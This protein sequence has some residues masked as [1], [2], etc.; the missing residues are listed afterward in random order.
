MNEKLITDYIDQHT[1]SYVKKYQFNSYL[2]KNDHF[3]KFHYYM[4]DNQLQEISIFFELNDYD[5]IQTTFTEDINEYE[6]AAIITDALK[7]IKKINHNS[8]V[9]PKQI[10]EFIKLKNFYNVT[11]E[12]IVV[13]LNYIL[14]HH[15]INQKSIDIFYSCY[16]NHFNDLIEQKDF[17]QCLV[18][19]TA[20]FDTIMY[21]TFWTGTFNDYLDQQYYL[22]L[23]YIKTIFNI[24]IHKMNTSV[25]VYKDE[26][27][28][29]LSNI[30]H[31]PRFTLCLLSSIDELEIDET[32]M[33]ILI[34]TV[35]ITLNDLE[36]K[37]GKDTIEYIKGLYYYDLNRIKDIV[38]ELFKSITEDIIRLLNH[39]MQ[40]TLGKYFLDKY[41]YDILINAFALDYD[42][43]LFS[44]FKI[45]D[46]PVE[47]HPIL[48]EQLKK[49]IY[50]YKELLDYPDTKLKALEQ[51][52]FI[53]RLI[54]EN[55]KDTM[56]KE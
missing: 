2:K 28:Y 4:R 54:L 20:I 49:A 40:V 13:I 15:G 38:Q 37:D 24:I 30:F 12:D 51:I 21:E 16:L 45:K 7:H 10:K 41:G 33:N 22:H 9:T 55:F 35:T 32:T 17:H 36:V 34:N 8:T 11:S 18:E 27:H 48:K 52:M 44:A 23:F 46:I 29:L 1:S 31:Y 5:G 39:D 56:Y 43:Y 47:Y 50:Y 53:N 3:Y 19:L 42:S 6:K 14:Y 25:L 26:I